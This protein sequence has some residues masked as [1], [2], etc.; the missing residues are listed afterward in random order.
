M[1]SDS[2][3]DPEADDSQYRPEES[4][5]EP[6]PLSRYARLILLILLVVSLFLLLW[7]TVDVFLLIFAGILLAIFLRAL[8]DWLSEHSPLSGGWSLAVVVLVLI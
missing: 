8:S 5:Y 7:Y 6:V 1:V 2:R 3:S 4:R